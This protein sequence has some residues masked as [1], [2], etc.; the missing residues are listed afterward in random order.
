MEMPSSGLFILR[1]DRAGHGCYRENPPQS[2]FG[3]G[4][5]CFLSP[6][7]KGGRGDFIDGGEHRRRVHDRWRYVVVPLPEQRPQRHPITA[8]P[9][10]V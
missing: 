10:T 4:P 1:C 9:A 5:G 3:K 6:L 8:R 7:P 2:S